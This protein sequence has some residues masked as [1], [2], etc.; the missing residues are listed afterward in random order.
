MLRKLKVLGVLAA[1]ITFSSG[2]TAG[3]EPAKTL[4]FG[5]VPQQS[6]GKLAR[7]WGPILRYVEEQTGVALRF[8]TAP[9]IPEFERRMAQGEYDISYMNPYHYTVFHEA[10]G[11]Q[12]FAKAKG[13]L[14]KGI[15]VVRK[16]SPIEDLTELDGTVMAFPAPAAFAASVLPRA[17][18]SNENIN[19]DPKYVSS[20]DSVYIS[21]ARGLYPAGGGIIRTLNSV[22]PAIRDQLRVLWTTKPYTSHALAAHPRV[23]QSSVAAVRDALV[24]LEQSEEGVALLKAL[25]WKGVEP[26]E[27]ERWDD[28]RELG[29]DLLDMLINGT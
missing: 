17:H 6:A 23:D 7:N 25:S 27:N 20:H 22:D 1:L 11:Y 4:T 28:V 8:A 18:L 5:V 9:S 19:I 21:V 2:L 13:K 15:V 3:S 14:I 10:P 26:A 16:D 29:L 12:A 24:S